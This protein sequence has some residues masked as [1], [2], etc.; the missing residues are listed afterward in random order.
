MIRKLSFFLSA[1]LLLSSLPVHAGE[2]LK[3]DDSF[4][5]FESTAY[6][7]RSSFFEHGFIAIEELAVSL[8]WKKGDDMNALPNK[9]RYC[10]VI[11]KVKSEYEWVIIDVE[12]WI[13]STRWASEAQV[14]ENLEKYVTIMNWAKECR[15]ELKFGLY[16]TVPIIDH[17]YVLKDISSK[18]YQFWREQNMALTK[19]VAAV[20]ALFPSLYTVYDE[21]EKWEYLTREYIKMA[22]FLAGDKPVYP[23]IWPRYHQGNK[24]KKGQFI[25]GEFW[26]FQ[27]EIVYELADG[28]VFWGGWRR[29]PM[30]WDENREWWTETKAFISSISE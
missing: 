16:A 25:S 2:L 12:H 28:V 15:P 17:N 13:L 20:D 3:K 30:D 24:S 11:R 19:L 4:I 29:G 8:F 6:K 9:R 18:E 10:S 23:Y 21:P 5:F 26:K 14:R 1:F 27:L 7:D 22:R